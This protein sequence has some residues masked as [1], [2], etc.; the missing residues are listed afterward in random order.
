MTST[1]TRIV[2][3]MQFVPIWVL[4]NGSRALP[5]KARRWAWSQLCGSLTRTVP[6]MRKRIEGNLKMVMP[7]LDADARRRLIGD[8]G[9]H[10]GMTYSELL[11]NREFSR[12]HDRIDVTGPGVAVVTEAN[13][14]GTGCMIVSGHFGQFEAIR[15]SLQSLNMTSA[16]IYKP[17]QNQ[18]FDRLF[19]RNLSYGGEP[20]FETGSSG[21][22]SLVRH[23]RSGGMVT[24]LLDQ[25]YTRGVVLEF[26]GR[27]AF[28]STHFC[29]LSLRFSIPIVP[30]YGTRNKDGRISVDFEDPIEASTPVLMTQMINDSL[31]ARVTRNPEQYHWMHQRWKH[32]SPAVEDDVE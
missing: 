13:A 26:M 30:A 16:A 4:V 11:L 10:F 15:H 28:T 7:E 20:L 21:M 32:A 31:A 18:F 14:R 19:V 22:R 17:N 29:E 5:I 1:L 9:R 8:A 3:F 2:H 27:P 24:L 25:R 23:L 12:R 6:A